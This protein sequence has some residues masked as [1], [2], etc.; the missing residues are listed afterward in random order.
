MIFCELHGDVIIEQ[1]NIYCVNL[2]M[3][4]MFC[5][6]ELLDGKIKI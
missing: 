4:F 1:D 3:N 2:L 6:L 5:R